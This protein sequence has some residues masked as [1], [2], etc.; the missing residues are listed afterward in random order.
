VRKRI[1]KLELQKENTVE[2]KGGKKILEKKEARKNRKVTRNQASLCLCFFTG[3]TRLGESA[4]C[5]TH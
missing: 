2:K 1:Q 3:L 4:K 5:F